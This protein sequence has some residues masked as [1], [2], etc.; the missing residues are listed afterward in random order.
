MIPAYIGVRD[1]ILAA[2]KKGRANGPGSVVTSPE[3]ENDVRTIL[4]G[5]LARCRMAA[6]RGWYRATVFTI[7]GDLSAVGPPTDSSLPESKRILKEL[8]TEGGFAWTWRRFHLRSRGTCQW[9]LLINIPP[10]E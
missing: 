7:A 3:M 5:T 4:A 9:A 8:L 2:V 1:D 10:T 6:A